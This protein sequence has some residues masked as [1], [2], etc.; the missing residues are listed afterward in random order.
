[1]ED[2]NRG[3]RKDFE[4]EVLQTREVQRQQKAM[5]IDNMMNTYLR[6]AEE[7]QALKLS[8]MNTNW[9][10]DNLNKN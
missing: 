6:K 8:L 4:H 2:V 9:D 7:D 10:W 5:A 3:L 1:M